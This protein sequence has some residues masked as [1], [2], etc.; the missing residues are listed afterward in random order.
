M[1]TTELVSVIGNETVMLWQKASIPTVSI[2]RVKKMIIDYHDKYRNI[3]KCV[4]SAGRRPGLQEKIEQFRESA[5]KNLF[6]I[7]ACK[8]AN[9][10]E[11]HCPAGCKVPRLEQC[12]LIDQRTERR[13]F[14]GSVDIQTTIKLQKRIARKGSM[15]NIVSEAGTS[16][17]IKCNSSRSIPMRHDTT[18]RS[19]MRRELKSTASV[20]DRYG[21]SDRSAASLCSAVLHDFKII[22]DE[23]LT[24]IIDRNKIRRERSKLRKSLS[25]NSPEVIEGLY[26]DGRKD[27]TLILE[28]FDGSKNSYKRNELKEHYTL[29]QEPHSTFLGHISL[30]S[31][32]SS[33]IFQS[34][35]DFFTEKK[36]SLEN[37]NVIGCDGTNVNVGIHNGIIRQ[38][39]LYLR[40][41]LHW[42]ICLLHTNELLLRHLIHHIDGKSMG[43]GIL[44]GEIGKKIKNCENYPPIKYKSISGV[45]IPEINWDLS[46]D[47]QLLL[48]LFKAVEC[49]YCSTELALRKPGPMCQSRWLTTA[50]R[51][52]RL[53]IGS[54][55]PSQQ[56][57]E[58]VN[59][60]MKVYAPMWFF[61][62][63]NS[64]ATSG[65]KHLFNMIRLCSYLPDEYKK[66]IHPVIQR[67]AFFAHPENII[68][69][70]IGDDRHHI[71]EL[72]LRKI[73]KIRDNGGQNS[74]NLRIFQVPKLNF[75]AS[76]Y[77]DMIDWQNI[78]VT[79]PPLTRIIETNNIR[80]I[81]DSK[82]VVNLDFKKFPCHTQAVERHVKLVTEASKSVADINNRDG[83]IKVKIESQNKMKHFNTKSEFK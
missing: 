1:S 48:N 67:N 50:S 80:E 4:S 73:L 31:G 57:I 25:N 45:E 58:L 46:T 19:Q 2:Q 69:A 82:N 15:C 78:E 74:K 41:P 47:Q 64:Y 33:N 79:E 44:G 55:S 81:I 43:P 12:F 23:N 68:L 3:L 72:G 51:V 18:K 49:G 36:I 10:D 75:D 40:R 52:L 16:S 28:H 83:Y 59:F 77:Y 13:M 35:I 38:L 60:I 32:H 76:A 61:I 9:F 29:L 30:A 34:I 27:Q 24:Q 66:I 7:S 26:F 37:L 62:K 8:C 20:C 71:R 11:C 63:Q 70:M 42:F 39:E 14:I 65:A 17:A 6:D 54:I 22:D 56:L 21:I 5:T 53:Y